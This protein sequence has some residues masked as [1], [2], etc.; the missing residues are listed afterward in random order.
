MLR[1]VISD[2]GGCPAQAA[3]LKPP[4]A[5]RMAFLW[6]LPFLGSDECPPIIHSHAWDAGEVAENTDSGLHAS[7]CSRLD[8]DAVHDDRPLFVVR[9]RIDFENTLHELVRTVDS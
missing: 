1:R 4:V 3:D 6:P 7:R 5:Q 8:G 2:H 9:R